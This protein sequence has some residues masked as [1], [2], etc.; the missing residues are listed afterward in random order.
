[1]NAPKGALFEPLSSRTDAVSFGKGCKGVFYK[2]SGDTFG[3]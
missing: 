2:V 3:E 1:M